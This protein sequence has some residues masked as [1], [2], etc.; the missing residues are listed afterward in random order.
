MTRRR[1]LVRKLDGVWQ[2]FDPEGNL[3]YAAEDWRTVYAFA[4]LGLG[5]IKPINNDFLKGLFG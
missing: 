4:R 2:A 1:W 5:P 3:R